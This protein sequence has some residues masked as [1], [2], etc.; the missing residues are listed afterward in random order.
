MSRWRCSRYVIGVCWMCL[1]SGGWATAG[2]DCSSLAATTSTCDTLAD[3]GDAP[4]SARPLLVTACHLGL[5]PPCGGRAG[6]SFACPGEFVTREDMA[7]FLERLYQVAG[8]GYEPPPAQGL[9]ADVP[10]TYCLAAWIEQL[11]N[12][13]ITAGCGGNTYCPFDALPRWQM[14]VFLARVILWRLEGT[15][16]VMPVSG[17]IG[18]R[19]YNCVDGAGGVS[20]FADI[21]ADKSLKCK[22]I[23]YIYSKAITSGCQKKDEPLRYCPDELIPRQEMAVFLVKASNRIGGN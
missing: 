8:A 2:E 3:L 5:M 14:A 6:E 16:A 12:D 15:G 13:N 21:V 19:S 18:G 20:L 23:H 9:F 1:A 17:V 22:A 7:I 4:G 10:A 11:K